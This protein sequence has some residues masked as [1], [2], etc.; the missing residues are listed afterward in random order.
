METKD[1]ILE[2]N[3]GRYLSSLI[4]GDRRGCAKI[5]ELENER[6]IPVIP[7][8]EGL[9]QRSLYRVGELWEMNRISVATEHM[10]TS[11]TEGFMNQ[12]YSRVISPVRTGKKA[13]L[14]SAENEMHQVGAKMAADVFEM[15]G[16]DSYYLGA[17]TPTGELMRFVDEIKP[18]V[19]G[20]SLSVY[21]HMGDLEK[22]LH[23]L[24][25]RFPDLPVMIGGQAFRHGTTHLAD[26]CRGVSAVL[27]LDELKGVIQKIDETGR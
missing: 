19:V 24:N 25:T 21:F 2:E 9:F 4:K 14:A 23:A 13:I 6:R 26:P 5:L 1:L 18:D 10:A 3:Y 20:L 11:I 8:Y 22:M 12:L 16:W 17:N 27:T 7:L 15:H